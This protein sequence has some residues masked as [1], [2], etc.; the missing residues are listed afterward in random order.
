MKSRKNPENYHGTP[1]HMND[2]VWVTEFRWDK[3]THRLTVLMAHGRNLNKLSGNPDIVIA[4]EISLYWMM[5]F[6]AGF[7]HFEY[8]KSED[9][10]FIVWTREKR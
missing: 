5:M 3:R 10:N 4:D 7:T 9:E 2:L 8:H 1:F 6:I